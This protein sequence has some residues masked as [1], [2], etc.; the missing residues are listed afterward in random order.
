MP[1]YLHQVQRRNGKPLSSAA[2][3]FWV[4][5][6]DRFAGFDEV[7]PSVATIAR[8]L[9]ISESSVD[10]HLR[11]LREVG[12]LVS[13]K[14]TGPHGSLPSIYAFAPFRP[15]HWDRRLEGCER[16]GIRI[17]GK[18]PGVMPSDMG[19]R[20]KG[21]A[22][23]GD[24]TSDVSGDVKNDAHNQ[25]LRVNQDLS[26]APSARSATT[27][28]GQ[29]TGSS[30][31]GTDE[32][33]RRGDE[34]P[35]IPGQQERE[36]VASWS[37]EEGRAFQLLLATLPDDFLAAAGVGERGLPVTVCQEVR[38]LLAADATVTAQRLAERVGRRW[39]DWGMEPAWYA[40]EVRSPIGVLKS[41]LRPE[42]PVPDCEA[43]TLLGGGDC[44]TCEARQEA[45]P[46]RAAPV[47]VR[48]WDSECGR[49][50]LPM[51]REDLDEIGWCS[52]CPGEAL[53]ALEAALG[54]PS[55]EA[56]DAVITETPRTSSV[57][58][59]GAPDGES[60]EQRAQDAGTLP[61]VDLD[62]SYE[63]AELGRPD[64]ERWRV[65]QHARR[66]AEWLARQ[67]AERAAGEA[68]DQA[69]DVEHG[70]AAKPVAL[71]PEVSTRA[72]ELRSLLRENKHRS[73]GGR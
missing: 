8:G 50:G 39:T 30:R 7:F 53:A 59:V 41:L 63:A 45:R 17:L 57:A 64:Y 66:K 35:T 55:G 5:F 21:A 48:G 51:D 10:R 12:A 69:V 71:D 14:R 27:A 24:V 26:G 44:S 18:V 9:S 36:P 43:G 56:G 15:W 54:G 13:A 31:A 40:G 60:D 49:C 6:Y 23:R 19:I 2:R 58:S 70:Q 42:C 16:R 73:R 61:D 62:V 47:E 3:D 32:R 4:R 46:E 29:T 1:N 11:A 33:L 25:D 28:G 72:S 37:R 22:Q 38:R 68:E 52:R 20:R 65:E 34:T 67:A